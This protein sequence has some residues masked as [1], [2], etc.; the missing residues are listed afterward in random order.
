MNLCPDIGL[1][2]E[3]STLI[4]RFPYLKVLD[5]HYRRIKKLPSSLGKLIHL[6][7]LDLSFNDMYYLPKSITRL[8]NLL[9]LDLTGCCNLI[10]LPRDMN[11]LMK[12]RHFWLQGCN[13]LTHMPEGLG[14]LKDLQILDIFIVGDKSG[15]KGNVTGDLADLSDLNNL[16]K[17]LIIIVGA[18]SK[19]IESEV[20]TAHLGRK[21][22]L[23]R[24]IVRFK[25][26][27]KAHDHEQFLEQLQH[28]GSSLRYPEIKGYGGKKLPSWMMND[29]LYRRLPNLRGIQLFYHE[30]CHFLEPE[31]AMCEEQ[32]LS[33]RL[34]ICCKRYPYLLDWIPGFSQLKE[35]LK[36][37]NLELEFTNPKADGLRVLT[38]HSLIIKDYLAAY[39]SY[40]HPHQPFI[41]L[42]NCF[43]NL[44]NLAI[45]NI[46][47][48]KFFPSSFVTSPLLKTC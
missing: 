17:E 31:E 22:N 26:T 28:Q 13:S 34:Y 8:V 20:R 1:S 3:G 35:Q 15:V 48:L 25:E 45:T 12:L 37:E 14:K 46:N 19:S 4:S 32:Q 23:E 10:E 7:Y 5:L 27:A 6:R 47:N 44:H 24:L 9:S 40:E 16:Q 18:E 41:L 29:E 42:N 11:K 38:L 21:D 43:P 2:F 30:D 36:M 39:P 33:M